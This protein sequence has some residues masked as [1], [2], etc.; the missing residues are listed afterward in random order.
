M[1]D[2]YQSP[3]MR[4][5]ELTM[6]RQDSCLFEEIQIICVDSPSKEAQGITGFGTQN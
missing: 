1:L 2:F 5:K 4:Y 6:F 3:L